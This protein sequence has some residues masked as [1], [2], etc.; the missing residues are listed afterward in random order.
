[1]GRRLFISSVLAISITLVSCSRPNDVQL[2][3]A[4][5]TNTVIP[6][7]NQ[8]KLDL[9]ELA[10]KFSEKRVQRIKIGYIQPTAQVGSGIIVFVPESLQTGKVLHSYLRFSN[11]SWAKNIFTNDSGAIVVQNWVTSGKWLFTKI[12]TILALDSCTV[13]AVIPDTVPVDTLVHILNLIYGKTFPIPHSMTNSTISVNIN[14][15]DEVTW[16]NTNG[17]ITVSLPV[18]NCEDEFCGIYCIFVFLYEA[19]QVRLQNI[20]SVP[21]V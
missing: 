7:S 18:R 9:I 15:L 14:Y 8:D 3:Y 16:Q 5:E 13:Q 10:G 1:M 2:P 20:R 4:I 19:G 17:S 21:V 6:L 12:K 11:I